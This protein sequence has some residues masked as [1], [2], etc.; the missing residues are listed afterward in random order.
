LSRAPSPNAGR[1]E[2]RLAESGDGVVRSVTRGGEKAVTHYRL[3]ARRGP[4]A[5]VECRLE[6]GRRNQIRAHM[7]ELGCPIVGDRKYGFRGRGPW[8]RPLLHARRLTFHHPLDG[9]AIDVV[10]EADAPELRVD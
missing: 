1:I 3:L 2:S 5:L 6:T 7:S 10:C 9:V 8:R 4:F